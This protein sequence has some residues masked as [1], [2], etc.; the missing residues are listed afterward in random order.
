MCKPTL[1]IKR[2]VFVVYAVDVTQVMEEDP[3]LDKKFEQFAAGVSRR[4]GGKKRRDRTVICLGPRSEANA[5]EARQLFMHLLRPLGKIG[6][7]L[8]FVCH[9]AFATR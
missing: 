2:F 5:G 8:L 1:P 3:R 4:G 9:Q 7:R 6:M